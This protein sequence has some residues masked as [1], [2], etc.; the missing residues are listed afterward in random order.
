[1]EK[2]LYSDIYNDVDTTAED[3]SSHIA[4]PMS[5]PILSEDALKKALKKLKKKEKKLKKKEK[6]RRK[7]EAKKI[8]KLK[9]QLKES[10]REYETFASKPA[11]ADRF[12]WFKKLILSCAP[13]V[14]N[15]LFAR[16]FASKS[17]RAKK[18]DIFGVPKG[19]YSF[20]NSDRYAAHK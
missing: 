9:K 19:Q 16:C 10:H 14:V 13:K 18:W 3:S 17:D 6:K 20:G 12:G 7:K 1:M 11:S 4:Y 5:Y 8:K 15:L 2:I